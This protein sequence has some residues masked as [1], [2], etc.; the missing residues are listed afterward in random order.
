[1]SSIDFSNVT[2]ININNQNVAG[3]YLGTTQIW[4]L[5][6]F[7]HI[8]TSLHD[9]DA[10][11]RAINTQYSGNP[12]PVPATK[13]LTFNHIGTNG[14][15]VNYIT[16]DQFDSTDGFWRNNYDVSKMW[17]AL[18]ASPDVPWGYDSDLSDTYGKNYM[19]SRALDS[20][21]FAKPAYAGLQLTV[22]ISDDVGYGGNNDLLY[23]N[24][25]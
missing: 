21:V 18:R 14:R 20:W 5:G 11:G 23:I 12:L 16:W 3:A 2:E 15:P 8:D 6:T 1:M 25:T 9:M 24:F 4:P 19:Q 22:S 13:T 10:I 17:V 7:I